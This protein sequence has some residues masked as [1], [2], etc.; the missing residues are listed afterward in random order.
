VKP[1]NIDWRTQYDTKRD[2]EAGDACITYCKDES[3]TQQQFT[4][5][6]DLNVIAQRFGLDGAI[7]V[8]PLDP[9]AYGDYSQVPDLRTVMD[10]SHRARE[11]FMDLP[12]KLRTRFN[13][14]PA[15]LWDFVND[16]ENADEAV[17]LG[18]LKRLPDPENPPA[19]PVG[20]SDT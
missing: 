19:E 10:I 2:K 7:P 16:P 14:Q 3:K 8:T 13:N 11:Q 18:L 17:R 5:D 12:A 1:N 6:A 4:I 20:K 9:N 15:Q